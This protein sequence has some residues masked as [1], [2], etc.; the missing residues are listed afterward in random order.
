MRKQLFALL[1]FSV[2]ATGCSHYSTYREEQDQFMASHGSG[3]E[4]T[5]Q[6]ATSYTNMLRRWAQQ[7]DAEAEFEMGIHYLNGW[8]GGGF[9]KDALTG[10]PWIEKSEAQG[11]AEASSLVASLFDPD[12]TPRDESIPSSYSKYWE[13]E[14]KAAELGGKYDMGVYASHLWSGIDSNVTQ[15]YAW[16]TIAETFGD[17]SSPSTKEMKA[18]MT[19]VQ[20]AE[21]K[22]IADELLPKVRASRDDYCKRYPK[23]TALFV[24]MVVG[25]QPCA[26]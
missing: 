5:G 21:G 3:S 2:L 7:G 12:L 16:Q 25:S 18:T 22:R 6:D 13:E 8:P 20:L 1:V 24:R 19:D 15:A 17:Q 9:A 23:V 4:L 26:E 11:K 10:L 14:E